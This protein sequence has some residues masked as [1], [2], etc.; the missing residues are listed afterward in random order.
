MRTVLSLLLLLLFAA[1]VLV[2]AQLTLPPQQSAPAVYGQACERRCFG[3]SSTIE[4]QV[5]G[6]SNSYCTNPLGCDWRWHMEVAPCSGALLQ[7]DAYVGL[8]QAPF[9][10]I[11]PAIYRELRFVCS[12][13]APSNIV[14]AVHA[15]SWLE[16]LMEWA[17]MDTTCA[18]MLGGSFND[19]AAL[20]QNAFVNV[21]LSAQ[22]WFALSSHSLLASEVA[23]DAE[24]P[25]CQQCFSG[26]QAVELPANASAALIQACGLTPDAIAQST[27]VFG[28]CEVGWQFC[29]DPCRVTS[30]P[31][32]WQSAD[33]EVVL[34]GLTPLAHVNSQAAK[35]LSVRLG[36]LDDGRTVLALTDAASISELVSGSGASFYL[37]WTYAQAE[38]AELLLARRRDFLF[39]TL[40]FALLTDANELLRAAGQVGPQNA[41]GSYAWDGLSASGIDQLVRLSRALSSREQGL[42]AGLICASIAALLFMLCGGYCTYMRFAERDWHAEPAATVSSGETL[43]TQSDLSSAA[44]RI[45]TRKTRSA[46]EVPATAEARAAEEAAARKDRETVERYNKQRTAR[47]ADGARR[48][49]SGLIGT[50]S[51]AYARMPA[52]DYDEYDDGDDN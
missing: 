6:S 2:S 29:V 26:E 18:A 1:N 35:H 16:P 49:V 44:E 5:A 45:R 3:G 36:A 51:N 32:V 4:P 50:A 23:C 37:A 21:R 30:G 8:G 31:D 33:V 14:L 10:T 13:S 15:E 46:F 7:F 9:S 22:E 40:D 34:G 47:L 28:V 41:L 20:F 24:P 42:L 25:K 12:E 48:A 38:P 52:A 43:V 39:R 11:D 19:S 17:F 27:D